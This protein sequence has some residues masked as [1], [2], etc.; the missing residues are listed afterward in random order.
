MDIQMITSIWACIAY[1]TSYIC[2]PEKTMSELMQKASKEANDKGVTDKLYHIANQLRKGREVSHHEAIMRCLSMPFRRSNI[3]VAFVATDFKENRTRIIKQRSVLDTMEDDDTDIYTTTIHD[4]Y[5]ARPSSLE[6]ISFADFISNYR[7]TSS[8]SSENN[9]QEEQYEVDEEV[10]ENVITLR[11]GLGQMKKRKI[12]QVIRYHYVSQEKDEEAYFHRLLLL[13]QPWRSEDQLKTHSTYKDS[14][15]IVKEQLVPKIKSFEPFHDDVESVLENFDPDDMAPEAWED[16]MANI[17]QEKEGAVIEDPNYE[18]LNPDN[19]PNDVL[20]TNLRHSSSNKSFTLTKTSTLPDTDFYKLIQSLNSKQRLLFDFI[21]YWATAMRLSVNVPD[22]FHIFLSGGGGV[23]KSH[24]INAIYEG[25][26]RALRTPAH[27]PD[28]PTVLLTAS[29]GKAAVNIN[30]TTLHSA[31]NLPIKD[32][33]NKFEYK[34]PGTENLNRLRS[35]Y[36]N[37]KLIIAD[38]ISMF[39]ARS[40]LHLHLT[41][42]HIFEIYDKPFAGISVLAVGDL[43]Q[44][45]PVGDLPVFKNP[46]SGYSALAGSLWTQNFELHELCEIVRQKND[47]IYANI[48]SRIRIG[49]IIDEDMKLLKDLE[50]T[51]TDNFPDSTVKIFLTN[52]QVATFN[53]EKMDQLP[54]RITIRAKDSKRDTTTNTVPITIMEENIYKTGGLP[55]SLTIAKDC[56]AMITKN[57]DISDHLVN[58]VIGTVQEICVDHRNPTAGIIFMKFG[59]PDIG[60]E[61]KKTTPSRLKGS[62]PI[63]AVTVNFLLTAKSP[64]QVERTMFPIVPAFGITAHK[65]QGS[66]YEFV[67]GDL[68]I[69]PS[70]K[71]VMPGQLYTVLSRATHRTGLKLIEFSPQKIKVNQQ[72]LQ[73]MDRMQNQATFDWIHPLDQLP[74]ENKIHIGF[75][76]IRSLNLHLD[77]LKANTVLQ[78]LTTICLTETHTSLSHEIPGY[79]SFH[80]KTQ[81][82]LA[83]YHKE[84]SEEF[85]LQVSNG[86]DLQLMARLLK[87]DENPLLVAVT[88]RPHS[89]SKGTFVSLISDFVRTVPKTFTLVLGGDFNLGPED[90]N[91]QKMCKLYKLNVM[92]NQATHFHGN[93][94][95]QILTTDDK[96]SSCVFPV[97]YSDHFLTCISLQ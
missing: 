44:L 52:K 94:L 63:K 55:S 6:Q 82:G 97:P 24:L 46:S 87:T 95:D 90:E 34:K 66:T 5:A 47:P 26:T 80:E 7:L 60:R 27:S 57:I 13:Y 76:N 58:G 22:P 93:N 61:A 38:E 15:E 37:V 1:I 62:V 48:L 36:I 89:M 12:P 8:S 3:P 16:F 78:N 83:Q 74:S 54:E 9:N 50:N 10:S 84:S 21:Y 23:G 20:E 70:M 73:E 64:V 53:D 79:H 69:P 30:G 33:S 25:V 85:S 14:F 86:N 43:L 51:N 40:L 96:A 75:L 92:I 29:T 42:Q 77:D 49:N 32:K 31:F 11:D 45:N 18:F 88:Y 71:T 72:A 59:S 17:E 68:T 2:K 35:N 65:S 39:G 56:K 28:Q 81:H 91:L 4:R 67:I 19:L 41:L